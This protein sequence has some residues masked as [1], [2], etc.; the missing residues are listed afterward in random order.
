MTERETEA[1]SRLQGYGLD[2]REI[3]RVTGIDKESVRTF[4]RRHT[5]TL[6]LP[7]NADGYCRSCGKPLRFT[8]GRRPKKY[9][10]NSC[11][12]VFWNSH[13]DS[14]RHRTWREYTCLHCGNTFEAAG[15]RERKYCSRACYQAARK[16]PAD[17]CIQDRYLRK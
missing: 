5:P 3:S 10:G 17:P 15:R 6:V 1:V 9:C 4:L 11:R 2:Y 13:R 14:I 12:T 7:L 16:A 8:P